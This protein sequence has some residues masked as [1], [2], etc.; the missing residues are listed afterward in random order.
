MNPI[1]GMFTHVRLGIR[2]RLDKGC[3]L[4]FYKNKIFGDSLQ[5]LKGGFHT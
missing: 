2:Q 1:Q 3:T 5:V 4:T